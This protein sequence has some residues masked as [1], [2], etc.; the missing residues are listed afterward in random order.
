MSLSRHQLR[1]LGVIGARSGD[2]CQLWTVKQSGALCVCRNE[3]LKRLVA[4]EHV[5]DRLR[6]LAGELDLR[7]FRA[8]LATQ[9][10]LGG[11]IALLIERVRGRRDRCFHQPP[12]QISGAVLRE[13]AAAVHLPGLVHAWAHAGVARQL[14]RRGEPGDVT[15]L[16]SEIPPVADD[17]AALNL[18]RA[19]AA[20][21]EAEFGAAGCGCGYTAVAGVA[22][23]VTANPSS[24]SWA[25]RR[26]AR[27][28]GSCR[29]V[30]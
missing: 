5:P 25:T 7:D 15:D 23:R 8:A 22:C 11:L 29:M 4:G 16:W 17:P 20:R 18:G 6:Q 21:G 9:P 24:S 13:R 27:R 2:A 19:E 10:T 3:G 14:D 1:G 28:S 12:A 30:K 26:R